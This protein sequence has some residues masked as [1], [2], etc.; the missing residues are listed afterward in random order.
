MSASPTFYSHARPSQLSKP[1]PSPSPSPG[2]GQHAEA[3]AE[4]DFKLEFMFINASAST[5]PLGQFSSTR[6][7]SA[8]AYARDASTATPT[9]R[10]AS[11]AQRSLSRSHLTTQHYRRKRHEAQQ[12]VVGVVSGADPNPDP[13]TK[14]RRVQRTTPQLA[15]EHA[16]L[17]SAELLL[18]VKE[19]TTRDSHPRARNAKTK[20]KANVNSRFR[21]PPTLSIPSYTRTG[22]RHDP[23][24]GSSQP[25]QT[26]HGHFPPR[27]LPT[28]TPLPALNGYEAQSELQLLISHYCSVIP[29]LL[30]QHWAQ[31]RRSRR[32][33]PHR[34]AR[35]IWALFDLY[36]RDY[37]SFVGGMYH[38]AM[39][40]LG[41]YGARREQPGFR[42]AWERALRWRGCAVGAVRDA[43]DAAASAANV[44]ENSGWAEDG[45]GHRTTAGQGDELGLAFTAQPWIPA[46]DAQD[47]LLVGIGLLAN[48]ERLWGDR[49]L[50]RTH[51]CMLKRLLV[52]RGG[53][54]SLAGS[55]DGTMHTKLVWS[56]IALTGS[57]SYAHEEPDPAYVAG[58]EV[59]GLS[60]PWLEGQQVSKR[61]SSGGEWSKCSNLDPQT[62]LV[63]S[64][65]EF[66]QLMSERTALCNRAPM[67]DH[68]RVASQLGERP[69][70]MIK[71]G[72]L[73]HACLA[74]KTQDTGYANPD[75]RLAHEH[76]RMASLLYLSM[77]AA[78]LGE[79]KACLRWVAAVEAL[80]EQDG[81]E[82][83]TSEHLLWLLLSED[84][85]DEGMD[86]VHQRDWKL[87]RLI[88]VVKRTKAGSWNRIID[89]L[90]RMLV[91]ETRS[92]WWD[93]AAFREEVRAHTI[94]LVS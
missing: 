93:G 59:E 17:A 32:V 42:A 78:E 14:T 82:S 37:V 90:W 57:S 72:S 19:P 91:G 68:T 56:F 44:D 77:V 70:G 67:I 46:Q 84:I 28:N 1:S 24:W 65:D 5:P 33:T 34:E 10:V 41:L 83:A 45:D 49:E 26:P 61:G 71:P 8:C 74:R 20:A 29:S 75:K 13:T 21:T 63:L 25:Q 43:I 48:A 54:A 64:M 35:A 81:E 38:A 92:G 69:G 79:D 3:D 88:G 6:R 85:L 52:A 58:F 66:C 11:K 15:S 60:L 50:G 53:F 73:L 2:P 40:L 16:C 87:A 80:L 4:A 62:A 39:H 23:F 47:G 27:T 36:R 18:V 94:P 22:L 76:C 51:W 89:E 30:T 31:Q 7:H 55:G 12:R 9:S 86:V